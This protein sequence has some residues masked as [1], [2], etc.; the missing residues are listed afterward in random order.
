[1]S[2]PVGI[3][4]RT[5]LYSMKGSAVKLLL[6]DDPASMVLLKRSSSVPQPVTHEARDMRERRDLKSEIRSSDVPNTSSFGPRT[7]P[8]SSQSHSAILQDCSLLCHTAVPRNFRV[9]TLLF[10]YLIESFGRTNQ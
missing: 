7:L 2:I 4:A 6:S 1:M 3:N 5:F 9:S 8:P 10:R